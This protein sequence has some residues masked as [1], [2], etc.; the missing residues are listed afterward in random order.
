MAK[1]LSSPMSN[2]ISKQNFGGCPLVSLIRE[3][4]L[5]VLTGSFMDGTIAAFVGDP[6][7]AVSMSPQHPV[8]SSVGASFSAVIERRRSPASAT[9]QRRGDAR[10]PLPLE[11]AAPAATRQRAVA[12]VRRPPPLAYSFGDCWGSLALGV[13]AAALCVGTVALCVATCLQAL[14]SSGVPQLFGPLSWAA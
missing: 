3:R 2:H 11:A 14:G 12:A 9:Q 1:R 4:T 5:S 6:S 13:V 7:S 10:A 8:P